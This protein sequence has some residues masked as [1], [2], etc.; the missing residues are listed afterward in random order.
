MYNGYE[1]NT[2]IIIDLFLFFDLHV[3]RAYILYTFLI[4][5][6]Y[7]KH[8]LFLGQTKTKGYVFR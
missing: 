3:R 5:Y 8:D 6:Y 2:L 1:I 4:E 7:I